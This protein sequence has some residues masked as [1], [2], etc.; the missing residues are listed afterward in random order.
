MAE[1][2]LLTMHQHFCRHRVMVTQYKYDTGVMLVSSIIPYLV[3]YYA[4]G[5]TA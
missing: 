2:Y 5:N 1:K 3:V 4:R